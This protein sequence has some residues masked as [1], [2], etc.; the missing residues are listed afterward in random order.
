M[1]FEPYCKIL[2]VGERSSNVDPRFHGCFFVCDMD[3]P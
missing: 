1:G 2:F 3:C